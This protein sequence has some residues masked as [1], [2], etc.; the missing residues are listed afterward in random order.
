MSSN[1][2]GSCRAK[3]CGIVL[4]VLMSFLFS[5]QSLGTEKKVQR[6]PPPRKTDTDF[7]RL[8][9]KKAPTS[10]IILI[11]KALCSLKRTVDLPFKGT[12]TA[13]EVQAGQAV[14]KGDVLA[15]YRLTPEI[16]LSLRRETMP[17]GVKRLEEEGALTAPI[18]GHVV[19]VHPE[20]RQGA[21]LGPMNRVFEVGVMDPMRLSAHV[22]EEE[23]LRLDLGDKGIVRPESLPGW[24][25]KAQVSRISWS[26][27]SLDPLQPSYY[28]VE[29]T[30]KNPGLILREGLRVII[31][32]F[33]P[34][35]RK[36]HGP[37]AGDSG[38]SSTSQ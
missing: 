22:Y 32:L 10:D 23:A 18:T 35:S 25:F 13:L 27:L 24:K 3:R 30:V 9:P 19:W 5:S 16:V 15:R 34:V 36:T 38:G 28:E 20:I 31:H 6:M 2:K 11:G 4:L 7:Q 1:Q 14:N 21:R 37:A 26:P 29:F 17:S 12:I 8:L 33:K